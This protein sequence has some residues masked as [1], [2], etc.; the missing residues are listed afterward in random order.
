MDARGGAVLVTSGVTVLHD[1][2]RVCAG[3]RNDF[4][5]GL[6]LLRSMCRP[7]RSASL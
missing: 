3:V 2:A 6:Q 5:D 7:K 4:E 1:A